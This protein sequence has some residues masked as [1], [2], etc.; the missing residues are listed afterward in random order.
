MT[1]DDESQLMANCSIVFDFLEC[2][3]VILHLLRVA[4]VLDDEHV[5]KHFEKVEVI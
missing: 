4:Q 5:L 1:I 3:T 2:E